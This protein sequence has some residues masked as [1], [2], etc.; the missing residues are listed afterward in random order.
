M[1]PFLDQVVATLRAPQVVTRHR[2]HAD[3]LCLFRNW[4]TLA[5]FPAKWLEAMALIPGPSERGMLLSAW[6]TNN[7]RGGEIVWLGQMRL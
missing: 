2:R 7:L 3:R 5:G 6:P 1:E 4:E